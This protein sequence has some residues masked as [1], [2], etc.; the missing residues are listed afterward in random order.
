MSRCTIGLDFGTNSVRALIVD[1]ATGEEIAAG[2]Q[3]YRRGD[4][5]VITDETDPLLA[6]QD[7]IDWLEGMTAAVAEALAAASTQGRFE[8]ADIIGCGVD[9]TGSTPLPVDEQC[10]PLAFSERFRDNPAALAW[11]WKDHTASTEAAQITEAA[12]RTRPQ[13]L[14][15]CGGTYSSEWLWSKVWHCLRTAP[16]V[17]DAAFTWVECSDWIPALLAGATRP[18]QIRR[19]RCAAGHKG[20]FNPSWGGYP[21]EG[22]IGSLDERLVRLRRTLPDQ[23][24]TIAEGAGRLCQ[25]WADRLGLPAGIPVAMG[26]LDAHMGVVG[27]GI[28]P[29]LYMKVMGTS[30]CDMVVHPL[31]EDLADIPGLCGIVPGSILPDAYGLEAGQAGF[32]DIYNWFVKE[33]RPGGPGGG[34]HEELTRGAGELKPG[35]SGLLVL[36]WHNGNR[37]VLVD[38]RLSGLLMGMNLRTTPAEIYRA[39]IEGTAFGARVIMER[40]EQ[41]GLEFDRVIAAG[42]IPDKNPVLIQIFAD[43]T[44]KV[45]EISRSTQSGALGAAMAAAVV[46]RAHGDFAQAAAAMTGVQAK[47]YV[48]DPRATQV[49]GRLYSLYRQL[50]DI[51]GTRDYTANLFNVMKELLAIRDAARG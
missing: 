17:Y 19:N 31:D 18:D 10:R 37:C 50:H 51:F 5:G 45:M 49:Y 20:M 14:A 27:C 32:G 41:Y 30:G 3:D 22:F 40:F 8:P 44:G 1:V 11:L 16:E 21:D 39:L 46:A 34:S 29:G 48:P 2:V 4:A 36:D 38:D 12:A 15:K 42:G 13:Y 25:E 7:P 28:R 26:A 24:P 23:A 35:E 6:R 9:T 43:V 33:V 47:R